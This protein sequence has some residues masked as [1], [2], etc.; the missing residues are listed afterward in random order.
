MNIVQSILTKNPCYTAGRKIKPQGLMLHSVG[1]G[2]P[3]AQVFVKRWNSESYNRACIHA[4]IDANDGTVY[5]TLPWDHRAWHSGGAANNT[6]IGVEMCES[7]YIKYIGVSD[8]FEVLNSAAAK[9]HATVAYKAA[10][11][12]FAYLCKMYGLDPIRDIISHNEGHKRGIASGHS[13]PEHYWTQLGIGYTMAGFRQDV[14][15]AMNGTVTVTTS[16]VKEVEEDMALPSLKKGA[17]GDAVKVLQK[18]LVASGY[19]CGKAGI[20][21]D[22]GNGTLEAVEKFQRDN[23]LSPDG[24]VGVKTWEALGATPLLSYDK[25]EYNELYASADAF[26]TRVQNAVDAFVL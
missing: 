26:R 18:L 8:K 6:H 14:K 1:V 4:F 11:E 2:Q 12:L 13:D 22:F 16:Q 23:K 20:D 25:T 19:D 5:Q 24:V 7:S 9:A 17:N 3:S 21:G 10:V 15:N